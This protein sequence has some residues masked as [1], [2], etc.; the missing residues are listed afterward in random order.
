MLNKQ[1]EQE[2]ANRGPGSYALASERLN[3][4]K[5]ISQHQKSAF[6]T[7]EPRKLDN[8]EMGVQ[9]N[10]A[11]NHYS[12]PDLVEVR[13]PE[14]RSAAFLNKARLP[15][16]TPSVGNPSPT[17]YDSN[18]YSTIGYQSLQGGAPNNI[19]TLKKA[20]D[21]MLSDILFPFLVNPRMAHSK[22]VMQTMDMGPGKYLGHS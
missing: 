16:L 11:P 18:S 4:M 12:Q 22:E 13:N 21:K 14:N 20:E 10:P 19:L 8:R 6:G 2:A 1:K 15:N 17:T 3:N 9:E 7:N 5:A